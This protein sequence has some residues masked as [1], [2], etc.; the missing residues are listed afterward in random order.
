MLRLALVGMFIVV[1]FGFAAVETSAA[2]G[3]RRKLTQIT[4]VEVKDTAQTRSQ[5]PFLG[6]IFKE[7][8]ADAI[9]ATPSELIPQVYAASL[10]NGEGRSDFGFA[11]VSSP[12][13]CGTAGC[14]FKAFTID[15][16]GSSKTVLSTYAHI[17]ESFFLSGCSSYISI[18]F[19]SGHGKTT[20]WTEWRFTDTSFEQMSSYKD[21]S[22]LP[23]CVEGSPGD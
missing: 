8:A 5:Y 13:H 16:G 19:V 22:F 1:T 10:P 20:Q 14:P 18:L 23:A 21:L 12:I 15:D 4:L 3:A 6:E 9:D 2:E 7:L 17:P 11:L